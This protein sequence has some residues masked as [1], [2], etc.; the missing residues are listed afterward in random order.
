MKIKKIELAAI[1]A[2]IMALSGL[3]YG[4]FAY[5]EISVDNTSKSLTASVYQNA[6]KAI[7]TL[8]DGKIY[9]TYDGITTPT[10]A[11]VGL[12]FEAG[13]TWELEGITEIKNFRAI[14]ATSTN[15][16]LKAHYAN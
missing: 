9:F 6:N 15:G 2:V 10:T 14:R 11:G 13:E 12:P 3:A 1:I 5:E 4:F 16:K 7:L 8:E